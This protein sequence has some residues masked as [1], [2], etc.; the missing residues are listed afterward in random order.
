MLS[1]RIDGTKLRSMRELAGHTVVAMADLTSDAMRRKNPAAAGVTRWQIYKLEQGSKQPSP[2][3][4]TALL[5]VL[6]AEPGDLLSDSD[7]LAR[8]A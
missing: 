5:E 4:F 7:A 1:H 3:V 6:E 8:P 2:P